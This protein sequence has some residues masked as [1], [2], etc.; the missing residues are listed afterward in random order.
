MVGVVSVAR[1]SDQNIDGLLTGARWDAPSLTY[2][3]PA[4]G[5][6]YE[7]SYG[8]GEAQD[9]FEPLNPSQMAAAR[10]A[11]AMIASVTNLDFTEISETA[12]AHATLRFAMSDAPGSAWT[13]TPDGSQ[14]SGDSWFGNSGGWYD[15]PV[16]GNYAFYTIM[17]EIVHGVGLKHGHEAAEFGA[18][19][20]DRD[21][22]EYSV[23]TYRSYIGA[24]GLH[25]ENEAPGYAQTL[26]MYDIAALQHMYGADYTTRGQD[27]V[28][29]WDPATGQTFIDGVGQGELAGNRIFMTIWDGGGEDCYDL[30]GYQTGVVVDLRP[31]AWSKTSNEQLAYLGGGHYARGTIANAFLYQGD[32]RSLIEDA[33]GG[34]GADQITGN[35]A[36]N[37][38]SGMKGADR[39]LGLEGNDVLQGGAGNDTLAGDAGRDMFVF[40]TKPTNAGN[41]DRILDFVVADDTIAIENAVFTKVG[42]TGKLAAKAF[43]TGAAAHDADDRMVYNKA[44][45]A[46]LYD[47]DGSGRSAPVH[48][49]TVGKN[50]K[51]TCADFFVV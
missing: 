22:M 47:A 34:S 24:S 14:E 4:S 16:P 40:D 33:V 30:S 1:T 35:S 12:T 6:F 41:R 28:Y 37:S 32:V 10:A 8:W 26:M 5:L 39:L 17:H 49:A 38:L 3:F 19:S 9:N 42:K 21:S 25:V 27:T 15:A 45:G 20:P 23:T 2:S 44:T 31:G 48:F 43:W 51:M 11:L 36:A 46:L 7:K 50:L 18:M 13:Y 29:R